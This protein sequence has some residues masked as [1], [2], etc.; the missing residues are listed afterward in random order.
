MATFANL[1]RRGNRASQPAATAVAV[2]TLYYV[3]DESLIERSTGSAWES[4]STTGGD[5]V[6]PASS[7]DNA[8]ARFDGTTGKLIQ[9]TSAVTL[10]DAGAFTFPDGVK[11]TFNPDG[12]T[13]GVNVGSHAGDPSS[14]ANGDVWYNSSS[15]ELK[16]RINGSSVALGAGGGGG[17]LVFLE[18]QAAS[19]SAS[20]IVSTFSA[21]YDDYVIKLVGMVPATSPT[22]LYVTVSV[23]GGSSYLAGTNYR[24]YTTKVGSDNATGSKVSN[25]TAQLPIGSVNVDL[26]SS[27]TGRSLTGTLWINDARSSLFKHIAG[28]TQMVYTSDAMMAIKVDGQ[29]NTTSAITHIKFAA[30]SGNITSGKIRLYGIANS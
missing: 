29:I 28:N 5:V 3:T 15:N 2:G 25:G 22:D 19:S 9:N 18:E 27:G 1:I 20:L 17:D 12:T 23:D 6:G 16:A 8:V 10:S 26:W 30:A 11:Q 7:T 24:Y 13:V 14:L 4:Y 21:T